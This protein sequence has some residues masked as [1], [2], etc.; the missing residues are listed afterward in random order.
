[1]KA[2]EAAKKISSER[3][4]WRRPMLNNEENNDGEAKSRLQ[5]KNAIMLAKLISGGEAGGGWRGESGAAKMSGNGACEIRP[6]LCGKS[7]MKISWRRAAG[8]LA[9]EAL[10]HRLISRTFSYIAQILSNSGAS[11]KTCGS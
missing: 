5:S 7:A 1:M 9:A 4:S 11:L 8:N 10:C 3:N 2:E 6:A